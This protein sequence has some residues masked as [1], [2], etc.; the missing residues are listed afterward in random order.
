S[1]VGARLGYLRPGR[2]RTCH[3][4][5]RGGWNPAQPL[6]RRGAPT[7]G[8]G[9]MGILCLGFWWSAIF[10]GLFPSGAAVLRFRPTGG[11]A[12]AGLPR[13]G[14]GLAGAVRSRDD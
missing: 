9:G 5:E 11:G 2:R 6:G 4:G 8:E 13:T 3:D 14:G 12:R 7:G 10:S 1:A